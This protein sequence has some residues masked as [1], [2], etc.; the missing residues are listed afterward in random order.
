VRERGEGGGLN[1]KHLTTEIQ[2]IDT[3]R[4]LVLPGFVG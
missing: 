1:L 3:E 4:L 2:Y